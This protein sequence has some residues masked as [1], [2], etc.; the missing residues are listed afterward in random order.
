MTASTA[1]VRAIRVWLPLLPVL[2]SFG[3]GFAGKDEPGLPEQ[4]RVE[5]SDGRPLV[6]TTLHNLSNIGILFTNV[7]MT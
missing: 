3:T 2:F 4:L 7:G 5:G 6:L 1:I